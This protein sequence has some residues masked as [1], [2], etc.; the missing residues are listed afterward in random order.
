[1]IVILHVI[2]A[3]L[4]IGLTSYAYMRPSVSKLRVAY[5][6]I[7]MTLVS[8]LYLVWSTPSHMVQACTSGLLYIGIVSI[9]IVAAR[10]KLAAIKNNI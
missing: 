5:G 9:G 4:S 3:C 2:I 6:S 1:M 8:G 10:T 7:G